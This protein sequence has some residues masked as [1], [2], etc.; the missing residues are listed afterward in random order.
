M[1]K[2]CP[3][4]GKE[5]THKAK[6]NKYCS[7]KC[8]SEGR[9]KSLSIAITGTVNLK[10]RTGK[11]IS[12]IHCDT[13]F[14]VIKSRADL[15][16]FCST[17]CTADY[18]KAHSGATRICPV[19]DQA[20]YKKGNPAYGTYC[21]RECG[22]IGR[23]TGSYIQCSVCGQVVYRTVGHL[24]RS[25]HHFCSISCKSI[26][27]MG[28]LV[29]IGSQVGDFV[30]DPYAGSFTT[31]CAS[32]ILKRNYGGAELDPEY[33]DIGVR[34]VEYWKNHPHELTKPKKKKKKDATNSGQQ[35]LF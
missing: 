4:C 32:V 12:C 31:A 6:I 19:C 21:S 3:N 15:A 13:K 35:T 30:Y 5:F 20:F 28:Y 2:Q 24:A 27:L 25:E 7:P 26:S 29:S 23:R 11:Y 18:A 17:R 34:R 8:V 10:A 9:R 14:Y 33:H 22:A 16:Q 1:S